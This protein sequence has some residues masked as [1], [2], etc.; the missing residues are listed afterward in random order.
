MSMMIKKDRNGSI[1][2][3]T[4]MGRGRPPKGAVKQP[5]G[6]FVLIIQEIEI[7]VVSSV[8]SIPSNIISFA[9]PNAIKPVEVI[10]PVEEK[11]V[12]TEGKK[13][14]NAKNKIQM[15]YF[16]DCVRPI[17]K[18]ETQSSV[19][20]YGIHVVLPINEVEELKNGS[21]YTRVEINKVTGD[22]LL[23]GDE[24]VVPGLI[25]RKLFEV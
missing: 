16:M 19:D 21:V 1:I 11:K 14:R 18:T 9:A 6:N 15:Q 13:Q 22:L 23:W 4:P 3:R 24:K 10:E 8:E 25:I 7:P 12:E 17:R 2:S 20:L 5:D